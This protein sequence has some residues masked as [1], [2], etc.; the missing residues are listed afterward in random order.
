MISQKL[1]QELQELSRTEKLQ[2]IQ[3]LAQDLSQE[4]TSQLVSGATY[5][6]WSP[7]DAPQAANALLKMLEEEKSQFKG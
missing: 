5:D 7:F 3:L 2:V 4:E 6:V 1:L